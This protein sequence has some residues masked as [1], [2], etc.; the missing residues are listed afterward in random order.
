[1]AQRRHPTLRIIIYILF[2]VLFPSFYGELYADGLKTQLESWLGDYFDPL[3]LSFGVVT[4]VAIIYYEV[5]ARRVVE[6]EDTAPDK[7]PPLLADRDELIDG[8]AQRYQSRRTQKL[9]NEL[10]FEIDL[11]LKYVET[12]ARNEIHRK[13]ILPPQSG[14]TDYHQLFDTYYAQLRRLLILGDPGSGKTLLLIRL[15]EYLL[16]KARQDPTHPIPIIINL[17]NWHAEEPDFATWLEKQLGAA[18]GEAG[19]SREYA[20]ELMAS[21][22]VLPLLDGLDEVAPADQSACLTALDRYLRQR[23]NRY[24]PATRHPE[25]V[26]CCRRAEF[27][28]LQAGAPVYATIDIQPL[29]QKAVRATLTELADQHNHAAAALLT[30]LKQH[31][32]LRQALN[33]AFYVH[34]ALSIQDPTDPDHWRPDHAH[35]PADLQQQI[36]QLYI[37]QQL[38]KLS[39]WTRY[40]EGRARRYLAWLARKISRHKRSVS[41]ELADLQIDW[42]RKG[43]WPQLVHYFFA[44]WI[45]S[46]VIGPIFGLGS[47]YLSL[48][49]MEMPTASW[50]AEPLISSL[51]LFAVFP[52]SFLMGIPFGALLAF[53]QVYITKEVELKYSDRITISFK[54]FDSNTLKY[55]IKS[56]TYGI[57]VSTLL[58]FF[59][60]RNAAGTLLGLLVGTVVSLVSMLSELI[61]HPLRFQ[62]LE[63]PYQRVLADQPLR[64]FQSVLIFLLLG[65]LVKIPA[66]AE[67]I[68]PKIAQSPL[69]G[70]LAILFVSGLI[71]A[72]FV[73]PFYEFCI[74]SFQLWLRRLTPFN[75]AR[76]LNRVT[77]T[78]GLLERDGGQWRFRH[79]LIQDTLAEDATAASNRQR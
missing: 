26:I 44:G 51:G 27:A 62:K 15:G 75:L 53:L 28:A 68:S 10:T 59:L 58:F 34:T 23:A 70:I 71:A 29:T 46:I 49:F 2:G 16:E 13:F 20:S 32:T 43:K 38:R 11:A 74:L 7:A 57:V 50:L 35:S 47:R 60:T 56:I 18:A 66:F 6:E 79:Q 37:R 67:S 42:I 4:L 64:S 1:M 8:M 63:R 24:P 72:I 14:L 22:Q 21:Y 55:Q 25:V 30:E 5:Q 40:R 76:F 77:D 78:T 33:T 48:K 9:D 65:V 54:P 17:A 41:F 61:F 19:V 69:A 52:I 12:T 31:K 3:Y 36:I 73:G 45:M 39:R